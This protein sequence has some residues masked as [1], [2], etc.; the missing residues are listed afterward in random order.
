MGISRFPDEVRETYRKRLRRCGVEGVLY[1]A[2]RVFR[3]SRVRAVGAD[4]VLFF[5]G[6][7]YGITKT[8]VK[9]GGSGDNRMKRNRFRHQNG[10]SFAGSLLRG[11]ILALGASA[12]LLICLTLIC[13]RNADPSRLIKPCAAVGFFVSAFLSGFLPAEFYKRRGLLIGLAGGAAL[14]LVFAVLSLILSDHGTVPAL[15]R[16][17]G[18]PAILLL[19]TFGGLFGGAKRHV[20]RRR[21]RA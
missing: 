21:P 18:Y 20:R 3:I 8:P 2:E 10:R 5:H 7:A 4:A 13:F 19:S 15:A 6:G 17:I 1:R 11:W 9:R 16:W 12:L 14:A